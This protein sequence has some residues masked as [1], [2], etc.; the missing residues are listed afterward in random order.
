MV[1]EKRHTTTGQESWTGQANEWEGL[2]I[3]TVDTMT[4]QRE[5]D[6]E[7]RFSIKYP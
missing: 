6:L 1:D 5:H 2:Q 3:H 4:D 7:E